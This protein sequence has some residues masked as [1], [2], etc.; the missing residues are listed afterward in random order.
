MHGRIKEVD[1]IIKKIKVM[2]NM[3]KFERLK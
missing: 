3:E 1:V 2:K